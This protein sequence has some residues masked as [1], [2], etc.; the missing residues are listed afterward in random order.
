MQSRRRLRFEKPA[1]SPSASGIDSA[2]A[3]G[4]NEGSI[5]GKTRSADRAARA[6]INIHSF[7]YPALQFIGVA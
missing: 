4:A 6:V 1:G 5:I 2:N 3:G 7:S